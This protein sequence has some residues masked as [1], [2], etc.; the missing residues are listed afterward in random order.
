MISSEFVRTFTQV[1]KTPD[2]DLAIVALLIARL[3]YPKLDASPYLDQLD[4]MGKVA[5]ERVAEFS[6][7]TKPQESIKAI[8]TYLFDEQGFAGNEHEYDDP[9]NS[10]LNDV[11][12][13]R[14]GIPITLALVYLEV[15]RRAGVSLQGVNFPGNFLLRFQSQTV[16]GGLGGE[17]IVAFDHAVIDDPANPFLT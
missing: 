10:F 8:N 9:R 17:L 3:E 7:P 6:D 12:T 15:A 14:M 11:L 5:H 2:P 1:A 13:R 16:T 4:E